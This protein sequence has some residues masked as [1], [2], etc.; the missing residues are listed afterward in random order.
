MYRTSFPPIPPETV[1]AARSIYGRNNSYIIIGDHIDELFANLIPYETNDIFKGSKLAGPILWMLTIFQYLE[2]IPDQQAADALHKRIDWLYALHLPLDFFNLGPESFC[3]FRK[4]MLVE[5]TGLQ[6]FQVLLSRLTGIVDLNGKHSV[7]QDPQRV[8]IA[9]CQISRLAKIWETLNQAI[10]TLAIKHPEWLLAASLPHWYKRYGHHQKNI[11]LRGNDLE[12]QATA[13]A[14]GA[15]G[16]YLLEAITKSG[17]AALANHYEVLQL[18]RIWED[19]FEVIE[20]KL[21]W[22]EN[23]CA[24][25]S[26]SRISAHPS[27]QETYHL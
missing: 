19:Q 16:A 24:G 11:N 14:I 12:K 3:E 2:T 17:D 23:F 22:R 7:S 1:S 5:P 8:I 6:N 10:E 9:V 4:W 20:G 27:A 18:R 21:A 15:D 25:C 13:Q 26:F